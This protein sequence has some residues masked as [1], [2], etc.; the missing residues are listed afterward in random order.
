MSPFLWWFDFDI[1]AGKLADSNS[2]TFSGY[3]SIQ[4]G[5]YIVMW[6]FLRSNNN[7]KK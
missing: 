7:S 3:K 1:Q 5:K 6:K 2:R 4:F